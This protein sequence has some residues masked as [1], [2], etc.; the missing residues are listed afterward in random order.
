MNGI[1]NSSCAVKKENYLPFYYDGGF[2]KNIFVTDVVTEIFI[3]DT[4]H[5]GV[6]FKVF[7]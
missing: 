6:S 5:L 2:Y 3:K 7:L 1:F 4:D